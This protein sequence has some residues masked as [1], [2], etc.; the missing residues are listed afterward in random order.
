MEV[1]VDVRRGRLRALLNFSLPAYERDLGAGAR[2]LTTCFPGVVERRWNIS[3]Q[4]VVM[5]P[6]LKL[7]IPALMMASC[8]IDSFD[9]EEA[10][11]DVV[12]TP[13]LKL[14]IPALM[15]AS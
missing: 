13:T 12:M 4:E 5:T 3:P 14:F 8:G 11:H 9:S 2:R 1:A 6:T 10:T 15:M 7:F